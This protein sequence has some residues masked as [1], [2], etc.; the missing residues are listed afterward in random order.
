MLEVKEIA[1]GY[2]NRFP[3]DD[4]SLVQIVDLVCLEKKCCQF[5]Q[6][7]IT[8][9]AG[10]GDAWLELTGAE[11]TKQFPQ[12]CLIEIGWMS[13]NLYYTF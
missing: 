11:G 9:E 8:V 3:S 10:K 4:D 12:L 6:V 1:S 2:V 5:L 7:K 13:Q